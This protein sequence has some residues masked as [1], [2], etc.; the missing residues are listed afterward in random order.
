MQ[1]DIQSVLQIVTQQLPEASIP[2]LMI[3]GHAVN[4]Y[5]VLRATQDIDFMIAAT[6]TDRVKDLMK[7]AGF[8]NISKH[9]T[10]IFFNQPDSPLRVDFLSVAPA[11]MDKLLGHA[12]KITYAGTNAVLVPQ[13]SDLLA[14]K[15]FA[16]AKGGPKRKDKDF[17]DIVNLVLEN[18]FDVENSLREL[19]EQYGT[20]NMY[21]ECKARIEELQHA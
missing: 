6:D 13:L 14:M 15:I 1:T 19:C 5:G 3:G 17:A 9:D 21:L 7:R 16:L 10:V 12:V 20:E 11:T 18:N 2:C 8:T 4:H